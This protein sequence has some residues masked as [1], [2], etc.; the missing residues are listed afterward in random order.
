[1]NETPASTTP[2]ESTIAASSAPPAA[3]CTAPCVP[4]SSIAASTGQSWWCVQ[5]TGD[6]ATV[7][8]PTRTAAFVRCPSWN[9][10]RERNSATTQTTAT[11][12]AQT[13]GRA[14]A[15][16]PTRSSMPCTDWLPKDARSPIREVSSIVPV[17]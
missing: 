12:V 8:Q 1:M 14:A 13:S 17:Q 3:R 6:A 16:T 10:W 7:A 11:S 2:S 4:I 9:N 15:G 5:D